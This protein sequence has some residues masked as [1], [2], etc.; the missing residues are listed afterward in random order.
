M[1]AVEE[2]AMKAETLVLDWLAR[3]DD[4]CLLSKDSN[5]T[6]DVAAWL[7]IVQIS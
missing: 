4:P 1:N 3:L 6:F 7:L 2:G 5:H